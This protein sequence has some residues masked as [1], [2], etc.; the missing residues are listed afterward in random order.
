VT[1][2]ISDLIKCQHCGSDYD[3]PFSMNDDDDMYYPCS[4]CK[5]G[6][7]FEADILNL[8]YASYNGAVLN[9]IY[10]VAYKIVNGD[11]YADDNYLELI[12]YVLA[13]IKIDKEDVFSYGSSPRGLFPADR[14]R[15]ELFLDV[16]K[17][18]LDE[19]WGGCVGD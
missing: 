2:K 10:A 19:N 9:D 7:D 11:F 13:D 17:C 16:F 12:C 5:N 14:E 15:A 1:K 8:P 18:Y 4:N 6:F 3:E